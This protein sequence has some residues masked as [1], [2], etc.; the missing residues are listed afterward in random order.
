MSTRRNLF[1]ALISVGMCLLCLLSVSAADVGEYNAYSESIQ[2]FN[3]ANQTVGIPP[4]E[5]PTFEQWKAD[6]QQPASRGTADVNAAERRVDELR[7][8]ENP[9]LLAGGVPLS[10]DDIHTL[11]RQ[12]LYVRSLQD[13]QR[14]DA[15]LEAARALIDAYGMDEHALLPDGRV[16]GLVGLDGQVPRYNITYNVGAAATISVDEL[17]PGGESGMELAAA[18]VVL[19]IWDGGDVLTNH[20]EFI[21]GAASRVIDKD[22]PSALAVNYHPTAVAGTMTAGGMIAATPYSNA[23]GMAFQGTL[24]A[25]DWEEDM[26]T[27]INS[28]YANDVRVSNHSYGRQAGWGSITLNGLTYLAWWG[29]SAISGQESHYFGLYDSDCR[30]LDD[31][32]Y[33]NPYSLPVWAAGNERDDAMPASGTWYF[34]FQE[35]ALVSSSAARP[36]DFYKNG[37]DTIT[38]RAI[39]KNV[40]AVGAVHKLPGGYG[41]TQAVTIAS[42]SGFGPTDDGRIKPDVMA[43]GVDLT[44]PVL[45]P[46]DPTNPYF[47]VVSTGDAANPS[48]GTGTSFASPSVAGALGLLDGL[49]EQHAPGLPY[50]ASTIKGLL[51]HTA[52]DVDMAGPDYRTGWGLAN[53]AAAAALMQ[54]DYDAGGKQYI[55]QVLLNDGDFIQFPVVASGTEPLK[56]TICWTDPAGPVQPAQLNP[57]NTVLVN[58]LDLR[59]IDSFGHTNFP[60]VLNPAI[61]S[62]A[63]TTGD[64]TRDNVEQVCIP[65]PLASNAYTVCVTHKGVLVDD[66]GGP[67][68]QNV[69]II[70]SGILPEER[71]ELKITDYV[72][73]AGGEWVGWPSVVGQSYMLETTTDLEYMAWTNASPEINASKIMTTWG[74]E[75]MNEDDVRFLRVREVD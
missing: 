23:K 25:Y 33:G 8:W 61:P 57:T 35:D 24:W 73:H 49:R 37:F 17:W 50:W 70:L 9:G 10:A 32:A 5:I 3:E 56:I 48:G 64:N 42:F 36:N 51:L 7:A 1:E 55:K 69:S 12:R 43:A 20:V 6:F 31:I 11:R 71:T 28:A 16:M 2:R 46:A 30:S 60:W 47:Y 13:M 74:D 66:V 38:D 29:D 39:A 65:E 19:G 15:E 59:I 54:A 41:G 18:N 22:G 72:A 58:D 40:L 26:G 63:A 34:T 45:N 44:T 75:W 53:A 27:E 52:D 14:R 4:I 67:S 21:Q 62:N 68:V